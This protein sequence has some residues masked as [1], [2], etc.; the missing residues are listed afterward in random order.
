MPGWRALKIFFSIGFVISFSLVIYFITACT[1]ESL[2]ILQFFFSSLLMYLLSEPLVRPAAVHPAPGTGIY[3]CF[4][5]S[6]PVGA[7]IARRF[8]LENQPFHFQQ[9]F[10]SCH[11]EK[12]YCFYKVLLL[13]VVQIHTM[14][15]PLPITFVETHIYSPPPKPS[16]DTSLYIHK[17]IA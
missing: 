1:L 10:A 6:Q 12:L 13:L 7:L 17:N 3:Y 8:Y 15:P 11:N 9:S 14:Y 4:D 5:G 2:C 16:T